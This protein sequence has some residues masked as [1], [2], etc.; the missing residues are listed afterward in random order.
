[1]VNVC[2]RVTPCCHTHLHMRKQFIGNGS[3]KAGCPHTK[4]KQ[5]FIRCSDVQHSH[6]GHKEDQGTA[7]VFLQY[8]QNNDAGTQTASDEQFPQFHTFS[9]NACQI[10][11]EQELGK[12]GR[13]EAD[14][15]NF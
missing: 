11:Y 4:Q 15:A 3:R 6:K 13:L 7:Q 8:Q 12:F 1:M 5:H 14:A 9:E 10:E 2:P